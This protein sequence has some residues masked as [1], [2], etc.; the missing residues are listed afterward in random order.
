MRLVLA[1][2]SPARLATLRRAGLDPQVIV[3]DVDEPALVS[4]AGPAEPTQSLVA[5]LAQAKAS[6]VMD[7]LSGDAVV[8]GCDSLLD[9]NGAP[10]GKPGDGPAVLARWQA[11]AGST[12]TLHTGHFL[13]RRTASGASATA[14]A[15][16]SAS[17]RFAAP[18][19]AELAA[20]V[21]TG[22]PQA[23]AG[24]FTIDG[25]GGWF[26]EGVDGDPHTV[27]GVSLPLV[28]QL[29]TAVGLSLLDVGWP[30]G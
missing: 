25:L 18:T 26:I 4:A 12:A 22:E 15:V 8:L 28:R 6:Q 7:R 21:A 9:V 30:A 13:A 29:L 24:G 2:A 10:V 3:S 11:V 1:S 5:L 27:V 16:G 17:V 20:Y 14:S 19:A 23:V